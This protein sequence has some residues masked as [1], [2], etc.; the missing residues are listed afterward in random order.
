MGAK[1][2]QGLIVV[3]LPQYSWVVEGAQDLLGWVASGQVP[4]GHH[5][6]Q[7]GDDD[8]ME[9]LMGVAALILKVTCVIKVSILAFCQFHVFS[10]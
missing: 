7:V 10:F 1:G 5:L 3:V 6:Q 9:I 2:V 4:V 8:C